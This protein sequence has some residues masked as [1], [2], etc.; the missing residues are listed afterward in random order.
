MKNSIFV[1][2]ILVALSAYKL[3]AAPIAEPSI[4]NPRTF[5][6][7]SIPD[8]IVVDSR[9]AGLFSYKCDCGITVIIQRGFNARTGKPFLRQW[10][11]DMRGGL[12]ELKLDEGAALN[13][14]LVLSCD[15]ICAGNAHFIR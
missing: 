5:V 15:D 4:S 8:Q 13:P 14:S 7:I 6:K 12:Q 1:I 3:K 2:L 10:V 11:K 9:R